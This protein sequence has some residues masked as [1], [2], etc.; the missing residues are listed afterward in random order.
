MTHETS[1]PAARGFMHSALVIESDQA[2]RELLAPAVRRALAEADGVFAAVSGPTADLLRAELGAAAGSLQWGD[3]AAFYQRLGFAYEGFRRFLAAA[4]A[5]GRRV[6]VFAEPARPGPGDGQPDDGQLDDRHGVADRTAAYLAYESI[7]NETYAAYG[8]P[9]TCLWD[10]RRHAPPVIDNVRRLHRHQLTSDGPV[11]SPGYLSPG[12]FLG[13]LTPAALPRPARADWAATLDSPDDL[14][15][16][17]GEVRGW[18]RRQGFT[19]AAAADV[20]LAVNEI[21]TNGL[22]HGRPPVAVLAWHDGDVLLVQ[23]EDQ[24]GIPLPAAGGYRPPGGDQDRTRGLWLAR[25]LAD[26]MQTHTAGDRT[27]VRLH[28]PYRLTHQRPPYLGGPL[29]AAGPA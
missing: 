18:A 5:A 14:P 17:R 7:C 8:C 1:S 13:G 3:P 24:G 6:A 26:V 27:T 19:A 22:T 21:V 10:A 29:W 23:V 16:L 4:H 11:P 15:A 25:Q 28:F 12:R 20:T 2:I 9:V